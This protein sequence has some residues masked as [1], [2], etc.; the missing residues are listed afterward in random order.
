MSALHVLVSGLGV[1]TQGVLPH[2]AA[3]GGLD[4]TVLSRRTAVAVPAGV[5]LVGPADYLDRP[6]DVVVGCFESDQRSRE[7]WTTPQIAASIT[8]SGAACIEMSTLGVARAREWHAQVAELGGVSIESPV[9]GSRVGAERGEL[10]AFVYASAADERADRVLSLFTRRRYEFSQPGN[11]S[12]FKLIYNAWG[13]SLLRTMATYLPPLRELG[14]DFEEA[15][16]VVTSDGWMAL[17]CA[18]KMDRAMEADFD[19]V[20]FSIT[21]MIKDLHLAQDVVPEDELTALVRS[22]FEEARSVHGPDADY[23]AV[24]GGDA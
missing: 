22:A 16:R 6:P 19:D 14:D 1:M 18:S 13:A 15:R 7:F 9:T 11:P 10:S 4:V 20:D 17:V 21:H 3:S 24:L 5:R 8:A 12:R 2:L 23:T